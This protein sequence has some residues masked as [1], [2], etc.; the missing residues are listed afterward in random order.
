MKRRITIGSRGSELALWQTGFVKTELEK[1]VSGVEF[2]VRVIK[3]TGDQIL[4]KAISKIVD[5]GLFSTEIENAILSGEIDIAVHSLKDLPTVQP[6]GLRIGAVITREMPNEVLIS[7]EYSSLDDLPVGARVATGSLRRRSQLLRY[8]PDLNPVEIRGN[9]PTRVEKLYNSNLDALIL[10]FAGIHRLGL[11]RHIK[12]I[13]PTEIILPAVGQ[14]AIAVEIRED[15]KEIAE[16]VSAINDA[17]TEACVTAERAFLRSLDGGCQVP[18]GALVVLDGENIGLEGF[19]GNLD[20]TKVIGGSL[21]GGWKEAE[22]LGKAL[23]DIFKAK[24]AEGILSE[25]REESRKL[26]LEVV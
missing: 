1:R 13:I 12:Q 10:A 5:K 11:D 19:V 15:D 9:V 7:K 23:A 3:T 2:E 8:R 18:I 22:A 21:R 16:I 24:G 4:D 26:E 20:G 17:A 6:A 25:A 14:A